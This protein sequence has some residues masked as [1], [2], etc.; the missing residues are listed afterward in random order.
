MNFIPAMLRYLSSNKLLCGIF[1]LSIFVEVAYT[2]AAPLS[3]KYLVDEAFGPKNFQVF[4]I[5]LI[6]LICGGLLNICASAIGDYSLGKLSG[7]VIRKLRTELFIHLQKQSLP[8]YQRYRVGDLVM[9]FAADMTAMERVIRLSCP[10]FLKESLSAVLGLF[11]LFTIEWKLT[12]AVIAGSALM[13]VGP[14]L[15]QGR[16]ETANV[17]YK[18]AQ[19]QFSN[20]I[21]EMVKGHK[22]IKGLHMQQRFMVRARKQIHELFSFGLSMHVTNALMERL[23]LT[24]LLI[25]NGIMIGFGGY[26]IFHDEM[27]VGG[28]M[29]FFTLFISVGQSAT[30]LSFLIPNLI[31]S[32]ISFNRVRDI[33]D[34]RPDVPEAANPAEL[35]AVI[36]SIRMER[37]TFGYTDD[38]DQLRDVSLHIAAG[39]YVAF[40]GPSGSGKS[41]ALQLLARFYDPKQ[42][43]VAID[44]YD[45]S[46]VSEASLRK[47]CT[48]VT[49]DTFLFN[50]SIRDNLMP[51][52]EDITEAEMVEAARQANIHDII[53]GWPDGYE[54]MIYH[55]GGSLSGG[56]RQRISLARALLRKPQLLL[57]D[58]VTS[59]LDP[60]TEADIN[61]LIQRIRGR[62]TIISVTHRLDSVVNADTIHVFHEGRIVESGTH[63]ELMKLDGLYRS[64]WEKQH[65][66]HL[67]RDGLHAT[68]EVERL[69]K[70]PFFAGIEPEL[71]RDIATL[72]TTEMCKEG[73]AVV[74][75]GEEGSKFYIIVRGR[76]EVLK[77]IPGAGEK[78]VAILQDGDHF[79][80]IALLKDV[81]RNATVQA[82]GPSVLLSVRR[83][84][85]HKLIAA[86]PQILSAL[87]STLLQRI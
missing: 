75:E 4:V 37:V 84:S 48:L 68:V 30:N 11:M 87:E 33:F 25:L 12:L 17:R 55:E 43:S 19:E 64:L 74:R 50:A 61:R 42:G 56:E 21:D 49:Q 71:L 73:D 41:T 10:L 15:L 27:T 80:E 6:I 44:H 14:K 70:L 59:A 36:R 34:Q 86:Y 65:G 29:A 78:R 46:N 54:T 51:E 58:E 39:S 8:F 23:P 85:F 63:Q 2:V 57:L 47:A 82:T 77:W 20:T 45:L 28:F 79:G 7:E 62:Q 60:A 31:D 52:G 76:F 26:L 32:S 3:L 81:P 66:F 69:A 22:T 13:F 24:A 53:A 83:E 67:S 1:V 18:E 5:I 38:A 72:F 16:A 35:P 40:V 9:R